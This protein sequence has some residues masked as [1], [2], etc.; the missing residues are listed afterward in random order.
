MYKL[1]VYLINKIHKILIYFWGLGF[2]LPKKYLTYHLPWFPLIIMH[3]LTNDNYCFITDLENYLV[4]KIISVK[5]NHKNYKIPKSGFTQFFD[6]LYGEYNH[7][8]F[9]RKTMIII[10]IYGLSWVISFYKYNYT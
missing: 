7:P 5:D 4:K 6:F 2:M 10:F 1:L 3:W 9:K 8:S